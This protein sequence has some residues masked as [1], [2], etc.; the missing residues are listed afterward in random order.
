MGDDHLTYRKGTIAAVTGLVIQMFLTL[1]MGLT[2]LWT[3]SPAI[4][5]AT[6]HMLG[7]MPIW[8]VLALI[9]SQ[10]EAERREVLASTKLAAQDAASSV[11][12]GDQS[13][14][15]QRA[16]G[17]L[18]NLLTWGLS[19]VSLFVALYLVS[20]GLILLYRFAAG[21]P[22]DAQASVT[23][24]AAH[25][26]PVGLLFV[27]G[28]IAFVA[29]VAGRWVSG[30]TRVR[31][32]QLLR[33][34]ASYLMSCFVL[35][36]TVLVGAV[37]AAILDDTAF[38]RVI[39]LAVPLLMLLIGG[40]MLL[41][42]L[43]AAY[44]PK[45]P[46][47]V[48]RPAFDSRLLGLL[49]APESLGHIIG[50]LI[51][52]QFGVEVSR[53]WLYQ[54]LGQAVTPLTIFGGCVLLGLSTMVI[55]G[56]DEQGLILRFGAVQSEALSPGIH[57]KRPWPLET[58]VTLPVG[59]VLQV[60]VSSDPAGR[61][62]TG[63]SILW[64]SDDDR[65]TS[66]AMEYF[67]TALDTQV[68][69]TAG[70]ALV[71]AEVVVQ[72]RVSDIIEFLQGSLAA[73]DAIRVVASQEATRFFASHD[74]DGLLTTGRIAGGPELEQRIQERLDTLGLGFE[75]VGVSV[76]SIS[77]PG[78]NVARSF[79]RQIGAE[80]ERETLIERGRRD[81]VATLAKVAG[82]VERSQSINTAILELDEL[83]RQQ[84]VFDE[85]QPSRSLSDAIKTKE[86]DIELLLSEAR[87]E[88][89]ELIHAARGYRWS[90]GIGERSSQEAFAGE[91]LAYE[92]APQY[93]RTRRFLDVL[94]KSLA[95][96][97]KFVIAG[98]HQ[99]PVLQMDFSE[100]DS[101]IDTLLGE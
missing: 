73:N 60:T 4:Q 21:P 40:E 49:T 59:K 61:G 38:F 29:F 84:G 92:K 86:L 24:I 63:D 1:A 8:I 50:D 43:L 77:P 11:L 16:R 44:R 58:A 74:L 23:T 76:T 70:L 27:A 25:V 31:A 64:T 69:D 88:A 98:D 30:Y 39:A 34:G 81:A 80:Q 9:Y 14:E 55:V 37:V 35:A 78:G 97:R 48:P 67:P 17:R 3:E 65:L 6:W 45:R 82:S 83:R 79:H 96:R 90:R 87:G 54:L 12:F 68:A 52:Y 32:W 93:Y 94:S 7:G 22:V 91:L 66:L 72:Y 100:T 26:N 36:A 2:A 75:I 20:A 33:G 5:A 18:G 46:G 99:L 71:N 56:P 47:E 41:A 89:A 42:A 28:G 95:K 51:Q 62:Q 85:V 10:H 101:A 13:D 19:G 53:S 15:L 57:F